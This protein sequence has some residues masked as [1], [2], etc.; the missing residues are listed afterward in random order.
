MLSRNKN[1]S[2]VPHQNLFPINHASWI[3]NQ[4]AKQKR[5]NSKKLENLIPKKSTS[6]VR[7]AKSPNAKT[8]T[9]TTMS[10]ESTP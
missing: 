9:A 4:L 8:L 7:K 10:P 5:A 3:K 6:G 2:P 1:K